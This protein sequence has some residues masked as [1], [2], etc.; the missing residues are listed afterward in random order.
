M[1]PGKEPGYLH[2]TASSRGRSP[3]K[4]VL[5]TAASI[6][7]P[8]TLHTTITPQQDTRTLRGTPQPRRIYTTTGDL[9][10]CTSSLESSPTT[11][12]SPETSPSIDQV[13]QPSLQGVPRDIQVKQ[14]PL[15]DLKQVTRSVTPDGSTSFWTR[16]VTQPGHQDKDPQYLHQAGVAQPDTGLKQPERQDEG[17][18]HPYREEVIPPDTKPEQPRKK[19]RR[20]TMGVTKIKQ[21][22]GVRDGKEDPAEFIEDIEWAY[23]QEFMRNEPE[24]SPDKE[25]YISKT[26]RIL[27]RQHLAARASEWYA[28]LDAD[29]K[30]NWIQIRE[31]FKAFF[32]ITIRDSQTRV[33]EL[34]IKLSQL[35][36]KDGETIAE[37][38]ERA[39]DLATKLPT[40]EIN[41]GM[42][43]LKG[44][45]DDEKRSRVTYDC[46]KEQDFSFSHIKKLITAA[47][48][49]VGK[50]SP[51]DPS[52]KESMQVSL[53]GQTT[54]TSTE[55]LLRQVL[56][57]TNV[58][59]PALLQG[60]RSLN[61]A[62]TSGVSIKQPGQKVTQPGSYQGEQKGRS[63]RAKDEI[64]CFKC[65]EMGH[66]ASECPQLQP[67]YQQQQYPQQTLPPAITARA[68]MPEQ[69]YEQQQ[70][71]EQQ[72]QYPH[73][74]DSQT[75]PWSHYGDQ[76]SSRMLF[77][78]E[79]VPAMAASRPKPK[80]QATT[81]PT[82]GATGILKNKSKP[83]TRQ[84]M[85]EEG[86][87][88]YEDN[89]G[90]QEAEEIMD[91]DAE[92]QHQVTQPGTQEYQ[93][94]PLQ[95]NWSAANSNQ[96]PP[97]TRITKTGR[98]Q[99]LVIPKQTKPAAPIRAM[100]GRKEE[101]IND[102]IL[103][104]MFPISLREYWNKSDQAIK[105]TA[106]SMQ[107]STPRYRIRKQPVTAVPDNIPASKAA[108]YE[109]EVAPVITA[110]AHDDDGRSAPL[111]VTSWVN[112]HCL[113]RTLLD[114]GSLIELISRKALSRIQPSPRIRTDGNI[115]VSLANDSITTLTSYVV[116]PINV[117]GVECMVKAW[118]VDV[119][120]Y[121]LLLG[122][123]WMRRMHF[124][125]HYGQGLVTITG[126]DGTV[127]RIPVQI[128]T[129]D[130]GLPTIEME[131]DDEMTADQACQ[132]II[133]SQENA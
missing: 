113:P 130:T 62:V 15:R 9:R 85:Q 124:N 125:T 50:I 53:M 81:H 10:F 28:D 40:D 80:P 67:S 111:M 3:E 38:L 41:V 114:G 32:Q 64:K 110:R 116:I 45:K 27:F 126:N 31:R 123:G 69:Y 12:Q 98:V 74:Y 17:C 60:M 13:E 11:S 119:Q 99:E 16:E 87:A 7:T 4:K 115:R 131:D 83:T 102:R 22:R 133:D 120:V 18:R 132:H 94:Q 14:P 1:N 101:E 91:M 55:E 122:V 36:Q 106:F 72:P 8:T 95:G 76:T 33:F 2:S 112:Q 35:E 59:F 93:K 104:L 96:G 49:E 82:Q 68:I 100:V 86:S 51:F 90:T 75:Q 20:V 108:L 97:R 43:T 54:T 105:E 44:M 19:H 129:I 48:S 77:V 58:A 127:R 71:Y 47:Y 26:H 37:F 88:L 21:F 57:N 5:T 70:M 6:S 79:S 56:I 46:N 84:S 107:R 42:A 118:I 24:E 39:E 29:I 117:E 103:D 34:R 66:Y 78:Q 109:Q 65:E 25:A 63:Y 92:D 121:D 52:Y 61:T 128:A 23:E 89:A 73:A 30:G